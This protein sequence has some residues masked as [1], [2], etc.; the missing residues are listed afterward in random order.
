MRSIYGR[1]SIKFA[2]ICIED[3]PYMIPTSGFREEDF[4]LN[5]LIG[6]KNWLFL[7]CLWTNQDEMSNIYRGPSI[8]ASNKASVHLAKQLQRRRFFQLL[9][10][11]GW[12]LKKSSPL[13][14]LDQMRRNLKGSIYGRSSI[15]IAHFFPIRYQT[16]L[17]STNQ[18][19]ELPV[20]AM[21]FNGLGRN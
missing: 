13:K 12:F 15:Q 9:F 20:A 17:K 11:I 3:L 10:L 21:F 4:F 2:E 5:R 8:Y 16:W 14:P 7:P 18:K 1:S 19:Q 6:N